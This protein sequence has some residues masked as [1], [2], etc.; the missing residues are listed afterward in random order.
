MS[1]SVTYIGLIVTALS[2]VF[3]DISPEALNTTVTTIV[4]IIGLIV[5]W[6][7]RYRQGDI[8]IL[9]FKK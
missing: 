4:T 1:Y 9:G 3:K 2:L 8:T 7:G 5:A 6:Y